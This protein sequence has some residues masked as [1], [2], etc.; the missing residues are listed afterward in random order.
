[1]FSTNAMLAES[2]AKLVE[3][4]GES[5]R[6]AH[7]R[8]PGKPDGRAGERQ[9]PG[10]VKPDSP[11]SMHEPPVG[12]DREHR[13]GHCDQSDDQIGDVIAPWNAPFHW[14][15]FSGKIVHS[16]RQGMTGFQGAESKE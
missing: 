14:G 1:L 9:A 13:E 12:L 3:R 16:A 10:K 2:P 5:L 8:K 15:D 4:R 7:E 11:Q 6:P